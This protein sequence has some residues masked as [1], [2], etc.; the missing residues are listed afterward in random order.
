[1]ELKQQF[2]Q[3]RA[4]LWNTLPTR[5]HEAI[6]KDLLAE[7]KEDGMLDDDDAVRGRERMVNVQ[8]QDDL[9]ELT[10]PQRR[11]NRLREV[12]LVHMD[13]L[14]GWQPAPNARRREPAMQDSVNVL[15]R[16]VSNAEAARNVFSTKNQALAQSFTQRTPRQRG[17]A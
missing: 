15:Q 7:L 12:D 10:R 1:M 9:R 11:G 13:D 3:S 4:Q 16:A 14:G 6:S 8:F 17:S 2:S 5:H